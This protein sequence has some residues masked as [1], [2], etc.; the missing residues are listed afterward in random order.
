MNTLVKQKT[1]ASTNST[2]NV[3]KKKNPSRLLGVEVESEGL[4]RILQHFVFRPRQPHLTELH[5]PKS[6]T[7]CGCKGSTAC[8]NASDKTAAGTA[9]AELS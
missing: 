8:C 9:R 1:E 2:K 6:C 3:R 4:K 5:M 7:D